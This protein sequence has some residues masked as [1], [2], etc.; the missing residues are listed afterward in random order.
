MIVWGCFIKGVM[1][2]SLHCKYNQVLMLGKV[3]SRKKQHK[4]LVDKL[5]II[6]LTRGPVK[7]WGEKMRGINDLFMSSIILLE[8]L[9]IYYFQPTISIWN[10]RTWNYT[11]CY[12][13][14]RGN[15]LCINQ[16]QLFRFKLIISKKLINCI[17]KS[18]YFKSSYCWWD[19]E[20]NFESIKSI[21]RIFFKLF[22]LNRKI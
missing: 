6:S 17:G 22:S 9:P 5:L 15:D 18:D 10:K 19:F 12:F 2:S 20:V 4:T 11:F 3:C 14:L 16:F 7:W 13:Q 1:T 8:A 21:T